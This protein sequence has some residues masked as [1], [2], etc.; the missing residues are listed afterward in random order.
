M[1][2][3]AIVSAPLSLRIAELSIE[4]WAIQKLRDGS[5]DVIYLYDSPIQALE[6]LRYR[7]SKE[8]VSVYCARCDRRI[9]V[10]VW[11]EETVFV[12]CRTCAAEVVIHEAA[13]TNAPAMLAFATV[14]AGAV[15]I[16]IMII[17]ALCH[18]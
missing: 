2:R 18:R 8:P 14:I 4:R 15:V 16:L 9:E 10:S 7:C 11:I 13:F 17:T 3:L 5:W 1:A 12:G 6:Y